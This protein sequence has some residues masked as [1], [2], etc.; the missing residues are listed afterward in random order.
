MKVD[1]VPVG[2]VESFDS[3]K[4]PP[5]GLSVR[6]FGLYRPAHRRRAAEH[7]DLLSGDGGGVVR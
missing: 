7:L 3:P 4:W 2:I 1:G 5:G 6:Q